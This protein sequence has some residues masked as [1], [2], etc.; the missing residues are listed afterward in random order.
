MPGSTLTTISAGAGRLGFKQPG[1]FV[2]S[3]PGRKYRGV[4]YSRISKRQQLK[5]ASITTKTIRKLILP[6]LR[7]AVPKKTGALRKSLKIRRVGRRI[8]LK[9]N[10]YSRFVSWRPK[11]GSSGVRTVASTANAMFRAGRQEISDA[12][13]SQI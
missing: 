6:R 12:V 10:F 9:G 2:K 7:K 5:V 4:K 8:T 1:E 13:K 11:G 3:V